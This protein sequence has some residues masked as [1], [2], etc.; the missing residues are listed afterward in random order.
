MENKIK[1]AVYG[2]SIM[3]AT[4]PDEN[5]R[6]HY[7]FNQYAADFAKLPL[8]ITNRAKFGATVQKGMK[9][10][11]RDLEKDFDYDLALIEY[12]GNDCNHDWSQ[13]A[14]DPE[15]PHL[16]KIDL[17]GFVATV[18][19]MADLLIARGVKPVLMN[20]PPIDSEKYLNFMKMQGLNTDNILSWLGD[21]N[22]IYRFHELYSN[23]LE[24]LAAA[25]NLLFV[26]VRS[27]FLSNHSFKKLISE[28]GIHPTGEGYKVIFGELF[29]NA[30]L[31]TGL[32][33]G[34]N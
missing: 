20:L 2:D 31:Y 17:K 1:V 8:E 22:M 32:T 13:V 27:A 12:G 28:D 26:D 24:K 14:A 3:K 4:V 30:R 19:K 29:K 33:C 9:I 7:H 21:V 11:T 15:S 25:K 23:A 16:P 6:Y 18:S 34:A 5:M 10:L